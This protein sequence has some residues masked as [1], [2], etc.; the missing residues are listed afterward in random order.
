MYGHMTSMGGA[1]A[2]SMLAQT[3]VLDY[4]WKQ[5]SLSHLFEIISLLFWGVYLIWFRGKLEVLIRGLSLKKQ[6]SYTSHFERGILDLLSPGSASYCACRNRHN[7]WW[8]ATEDEK[9]HEQHLAKVLTKGW[10]FEFLVFKKP[11]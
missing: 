11:T 2:Q 1:L 10:T 7:H 9:E 8:G 6:H 3:H 4:G 5:C